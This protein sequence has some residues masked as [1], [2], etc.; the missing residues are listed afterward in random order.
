MSG[1]F[2]G[3]DVGSSAVKAGLF[4]GDG[5]SKGA[6]RVPCDSTGDFEPARWWE[7][8]VAALRELD[9]DDVSAVGIC[10][11]GGTNVLLDASGAVIA[12]S[13]NDRRAHREFAELRAT[14][15]TAGNAALSLLAKARWWTRHEGPVATA[16]TAK[17]YLVF[18]LTGKRVSD[19]ASG[20]ATLPG[21]EP[22]APAKEPWAVAGTVAKEAADLTGIREGIPVAVGWHDGAAAA[23]GAGGAEAGTAVIT[24]GT[25]AVYRIVV[26]ELPAGLPRYWDL[27][28][29]LTVTGGDVTAAGKAMAWAMD[30]WPDADFAHSEAGANSAI[31]LPQFAG[32]IAPNVN[33]DARGAFAG[34]DGS[35]S[36]SDMVRAVAEGIAFSLRQV[37]AHLNAGG[38]EATRTVATGGGAHDPAMAQ[39]V[40][41]VL[42]ETVLVAKAEEGCRGAALLGAVAAGEMT[43]EEART[44]KPEYHRY[45]P[46]ATT[47]PAYD[48]AYERF[49]RAQ[50]ALDLL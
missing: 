2:L 44:L 21:L 17:D 26:E 42:G 34:L 18:H 29:G 48:A 11:R 35:Q 1:L 39:L 10:G 5:R 12:P 14:H 36:P 38:L 49:L 22:L 27:T 9:L 50:R 41:D 8:I 32:R 33:Q 7:A 45:E 16:M 31:F 25:N 47:S 43:L 3:I 40:A 20:G 15:P 28:P 6:A 24:L 23:F 46:D 30:L 19:G 13:R 4:A 37:R